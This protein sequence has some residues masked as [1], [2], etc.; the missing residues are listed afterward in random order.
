MTLPAA[1]PQSGNLP[2]PPLSEIAPAKPAPP[3]SVAGLAVFPALEES[4]WMASFLQYA[5]ILTPT[6]DPEHA[7]WDIP[8]T[9]WSTVLPA[10]SS[11][12]MDFLQILVSQHPFYRLIY[13]FSF[14]KCLYP[15][16]LW[17]L[18]SCLSKSP[19]QSLPFPGNLAPSRAA[20]HFIHS[21]INLA[22]LY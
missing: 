14:W 1:Q 15:A 5:R 17:P 10:T 3:K 12:S 7:R 18:T 20:L 4:W 2:W 8:K 13:V 21:S 16:F 22:K 6:P 19:P 9:I 11:I